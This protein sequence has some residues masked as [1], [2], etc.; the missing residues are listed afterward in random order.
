MPAALRT[1]RPAV[2]GSFYPDDSRTLA[3]LVDRLIDAARTTIPAGAAV[4]K[5]LIVPHAGYIYSGP[6]A[7]SGYA[8]LAAARGRVARIVLLG[9][10]HRVWFEGI[11]WPDADRFDTPLGS[12]RT[13]SVEVPG[14]SANARAHAGEHSLEVHLP[15]LQRVLGD[16]DVMPLLVGGAAP[17]RVASVLDALWGGADTV[18]VISSDLS[19]YHSWPQAVKID[20]ASAGQ[21][22]ALR[23]PLTA[24]Q[25]CGATPVNGLLMAAAGRRMRV[26]RLDLRNSGDTAGLR[27]QVV[28]YGAF[29]FHESEPRVF[30]PGEAA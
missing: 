30:R 12:V 26:E 10:A 20:A 15:F 16:V 27:D 4:P 7:A 11:A 24:D 8:R 6:I 29:A 9:P 2:A 23:P 5:A 1:R 25:A 28:G 13:P 14:V 18:I 19:H 22:E 3:S 17:D 21:I